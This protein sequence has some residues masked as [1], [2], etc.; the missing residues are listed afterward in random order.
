VNTDVDA[1]D[2]DMGAR[3][4]IAR[5]QASP[6]VASQT[7]VDGHVKCVGLQRARRGGQADPPHDA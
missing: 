2:V 7:K 4:L 5:P 6:G 3:Q 1:A